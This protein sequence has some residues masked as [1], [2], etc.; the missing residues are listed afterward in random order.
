MVRWVWVAK[1]QKAKYEI[2]GPGRA[3]LETLEAYDEMLRRVQV[4]EGGS[5]E[6]IPRLH[7]KLLAIQTKRDQNKNPEV[8]TILL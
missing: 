5:D 4:A 6:D 1:R 8:S 7:E 3:G 2:D